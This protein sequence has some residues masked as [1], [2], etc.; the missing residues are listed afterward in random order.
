MLILYDGTTSVCAIKVRI[1]LVEKG[2]D[3]QSR[4]IDLR[5]ERLV[6]KGQP[7]TLRLESKLM[8]LKTIGKA[9]EHGSKGEFIKILNPR[10]SKVIMGIVVGFND[11]KVPINNRIKFAKAKKK[12]KKGLRIDYGVSLPGSGKAGI[13]A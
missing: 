7:V 13:A 9:L 5:K 8:S 11:V 12:G 4:N 6:L 3:F 10:T 2:L 1:T